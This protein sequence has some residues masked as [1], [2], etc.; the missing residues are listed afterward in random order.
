MVQPVFN[1]HCIE[2]NVLIQER[3]K[4][5]LVGSKAMRIQLLDKIF[6]YRLSHGY[7]SI[8]VVRVLIRNCDKIVQAQMHVVCQPVKIDHAA[9]M[10]KVQSLRLQRHYSVD[11]LVCLRRIEMYRRRCREYEF[12]FLRIELPV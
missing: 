11:C 9:V 8:V 1:P 3:V 6:K 4:P 5:F 7:G 2:L 10:G 12:A